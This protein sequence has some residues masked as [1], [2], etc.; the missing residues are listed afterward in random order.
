MPVCGVFPDCVSLSCGSLR[1]MLALCFAV[2]SGGCLV[3]CRC[4]VALSLS[5]S[6]GPRVLASQARYARGCYVRLGSRVGSMKFYLE[7]SGQPS[8]T[9]K[10]T[11]A[12]DRAV[13]GRQSATARMPCACSTASRVDCKHAGLHSRAWVSTP[14]YYIQVCVLDSI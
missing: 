12:T 1:R 2:V 5:F 3:A 7:S 11:L 6:F 8:C 10:L 9:K 13:R 4:F 14:L